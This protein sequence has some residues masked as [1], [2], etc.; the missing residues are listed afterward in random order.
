MDIEKIINDLIEE[1]QVFYSGTLTEFLVHKDI[2]PLSR[3]ATLVRDSISKDAFY[4]Y[5]LIS[6]KAYIRKHT[7]VTYK[8]LCS[9]KSQWYW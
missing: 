8:D 9:G 2:H 6:L 5:H 7:Y 4:T 1:Y 3:I